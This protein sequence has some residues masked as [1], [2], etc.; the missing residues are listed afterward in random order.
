[1]ETEVRTKK[2]KVVSIIV[3]IVTIAA[4][5]MALATVIFTFSVDKTDRSLFG[6]R[7]YICLSDSMKATDFEAGDLVVSRKVSLDKIQEGDIISYISTDVSS[8]GEIITHKVREIK[9]ENGVYRFTTYGT[10]TGDDDLT[11]V[12]GVNVLGKYAFSIPKLGLFFNFVKTVP[13]YICCVFIPFMFLI[14][15]QIINTVSLFREY[16]R[17]ETIKLND[18]RKELERK[19]EENKEML[20][21]LEEMKAQM[22]ISDSTPVKDETASETPL[23]EEKPS[24]EAGIKQETEEA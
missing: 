4:L 10:T 17:T 18:E 14:V 19:M 24:E 12:D 22:N 6:I 15:L 23:K 9:V 7:F 20:R 1:M 21:K 16:K 3:S 8:N 5:V 13:G 11:P 2:S